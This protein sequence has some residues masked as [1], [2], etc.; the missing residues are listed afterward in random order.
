MEHGRDRA[1]DAYDE[2]K[3]YTKEDSNM[4]S[5]KAGDAKDAISEA[6]WYGKEK[7]SDAYDVAKEEIYR[8]SNIASDKAN[9]ANEASAGAMGSG[10]GGE[11]DAF[12]E[13][14]SHIGEAYVSAKDTVTDQAKANYEAAKEK[15]SKATGDLGDKMR[16][17]SADL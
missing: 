11:R 10:R 1:A 2:A 9:K 12:D 17:E 5:E 7:A 4:A 8:I 16:R 15:L 3:K 14:K 13:A 6:M